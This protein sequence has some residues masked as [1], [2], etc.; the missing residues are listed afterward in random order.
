MF[1]VR[2][3]DLKPT[4]IL[5]SD[6]Y[7]FKLLNILIVIMIQICLLCKIYDKIKHKISIIN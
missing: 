7:S 3:I 4:G 2:P 5:N 6:Y 1:L